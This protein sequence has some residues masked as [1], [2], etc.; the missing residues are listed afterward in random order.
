[1]FDAFLE[2]FSGQNLGKAVVKA[3]MTVNLCSSLASIQLL[4][5]RSL[6]YHVP[7]HCNMQDSNHGMMFSTAS[8]WLAT[9]S[10]HTSII[11]RSTLFVCG[12]T[13]CVHELAAG[14]DFDIGSYWAR[15]LLLNWTCTSLVPR[16]TRAKYFHSQTLRMEEAS[17]PKSHK[18]TNFKINLAALGCFYTYLSR[19]ARIASQ[20]I[21]IASNKQHGEIAHSVIPENPPQPPVCHTCCDNC[22]LTL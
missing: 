21:P 5:I 4:V 16:L 19:N 1:M 22:P 9:P 6:R 15:H 12:F 2:L 17:L 20:F 10:H 18:S 13:D 8:T 14:C 3:S 7:K 11:S